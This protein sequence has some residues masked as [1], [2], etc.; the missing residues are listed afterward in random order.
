MYSVTQSDR[1]ATITCKFHR[2]SNTA[3]S[4][5]SR[6]K[7]KVKKINKIVTNNDLEGAPQKGAASKQK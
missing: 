7:I 4:V 1:D 3:F 5:L 2:E 6:I